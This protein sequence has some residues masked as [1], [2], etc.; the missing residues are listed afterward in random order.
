MGVDFE[1]LTD[2]VREGCPGE[3]DVG[4]GDPFMSLDAE[5]VEGAG[6]LLAVVLPCTAGNQIG[7]DAGGAAFVGGIVNAAAGDHDRECGRLDVGHRLGH[8]CQPVWK[9]MR[10]NQLFAHTGC[11]L[12]GWIRRKIN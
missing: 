9:T 8:Q 11:N 4:V 3:G 1:G 12:P 7:E 6:E 10:L 2:F 5:V